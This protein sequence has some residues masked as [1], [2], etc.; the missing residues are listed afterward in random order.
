MDD[1]IDYYDS[2]HTIYASKRHRD[3]HFDLI[4]RDIA[5]FITAPDQVVLDLMV[6]KFLASYTTKPIYVFGGFG[7]LSMLL[8]M[9]AFTVALGLKLTGLR[10]FVSTPLPLLGVMFGLAGVVGILMGLMADL[11]VRTYYESQ[12]KRPYLVADELNRPL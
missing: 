7:L 10:D 11:I 12:G 1:W 3:L 8:S 9:L 2:T 4:A 5:S 6:V